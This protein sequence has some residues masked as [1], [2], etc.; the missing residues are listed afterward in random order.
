MSAE[1][2]AE[3]FHGNEEIREHEREVIDRWNHFLAMLHQK[4][5]ELACFKEL[6]EANRT[7]LYEDIKRV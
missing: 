4:E 1:L 7:Y 3:N 2:Q 6:E 5:K